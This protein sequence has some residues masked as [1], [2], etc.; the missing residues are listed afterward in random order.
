MVE[1]TYGGGMMAVH[2]FDSHGRWIAF[3][4][5]ETSKHLFS[6]RGQWLG[7]LA[8]DGT[9]VCSAT[10]GRYLG[11]IRG[12]RLLRKTSV[13]SR[14]T[15]MTQMTPMTPMTPM[16]RMGVSMPMGYSDI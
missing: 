8:W 11:T 16:T 1:S 10:T 3:R 2:Y 13:P 15:P 14:M 6:P 9:D 4:P 7:W 12:D 5:S